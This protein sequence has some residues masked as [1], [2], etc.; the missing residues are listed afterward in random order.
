MW[1]RRG[2]GPCGGGQR[3]ERRGRRGDGVVSGQ[4][5]RGHAL[6]VGTWR[7]GGG[8]PAEAFAAAG[9]R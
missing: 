8:R 9:G 6:G 4:G 5:K 7:C 3:G 2:C 1:W